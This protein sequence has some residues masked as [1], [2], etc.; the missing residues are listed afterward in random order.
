MDHNEKLNYINYILMN[1]DASYKGPA[2]L[3]KYRPFDE[4]TF[5]MLENKYLFLC[6]AEKLDDP[7]EC[8]TSLNMQNLYDLERD[9]LKR[10]CVFQIMELIRP[11]TSKENFEQIQ[12]LISQVLNR[13][14]TV[15]PNHLLDIQPEIDELVPGVNT[16][17]IVN[18]LVNIPEKLDEPGTNEQIKTLILGAYEARQK[19]GI[20]SLC[21][22]SDNEYMW[23]NYAG[24][25]S[26]YCVEFDFSDFKTPNI[27]FPVIY[28]DERETNIVMSIVANFIGQMIFGM[29]S[30]QI[31]LDTSQY[32][33]LFITKYKQW[34]YQ[35]EWRILG[36]ANTRTP[37]PKIKRII[38]GA[39][40]S[41][42]NKEA[43][44]KFCNEN[45]IPLEE[46]K[47]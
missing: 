28:Q 39:D 11:Y 18:Y 32:L 12:M 4:Y 46:M 47:K 6:V 41:A 30:H 25:N 26:G 23:E 7:T 22:D 36:D 1:R 2:S 19:M 31:K 16:A 29:S 38:L 9:G 24:K 27:L 5:D 10:Q 8:M 13:N 37:A 14:G 43:V 15:R 17:P 42:K 40:A 35:N 20:C 21:E 45:N 44:R 34:E 3:F 33:R